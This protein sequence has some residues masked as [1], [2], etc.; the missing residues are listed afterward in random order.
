V[1]IRRELEFDAAEVE[2][3]MKFDRFEYRETFT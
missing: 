1:I 3:S 2:W